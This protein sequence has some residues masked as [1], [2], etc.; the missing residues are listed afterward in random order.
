MEIVSS[1]VRLD[2]L[3]RQPMT[4]VGKNE[5][6]SVSGS[7]WPRR[8]CRRRC[9]CKGSTA[10]GCGMLRGDRRALAGGRGL[11]EIMGTR[12]G[13]QMA[14]VGGARLRL[15]PRRGCSR[16]WQAIWGAAPV[17]DDGSNG[18]GSCR[19]VD[20]WN[21]GRRTW[22]SEATRRGA[23]ERGGSRGGQGDEDGGKRRRE[24]GADDAIQS[25]RRRVSELNNST[26]VAMHPAKECACPSK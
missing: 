21:M 4:A 24:K 18:N 9:S 11:Q 2:R 1:R 26:H 7:P 12:S 8:P 19:G 15:S 6:R 22:D 16:A 25:T 14:S 5:E 3:T 10:L 17:V 23:S 20:G 13:L